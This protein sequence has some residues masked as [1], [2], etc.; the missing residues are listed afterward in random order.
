MVLFLQ[1]VQ[2]KARHHHRY[3]EVRL[4][5][6]RCLLRALIKAFFAMPA[7]AWAAVQGVTCFTTSKHRLDIDLYLQ[8]TLQPAICVARCGTFILSYLSG[9]L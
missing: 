1:A 5:R 7:A 2:A 9:M 4:R 8:R 3:L 6:R